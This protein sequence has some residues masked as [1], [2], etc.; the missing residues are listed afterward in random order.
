MYGHSLEGQSCALRAPTAADAAAASAVLTQLATLPFSSRHFGLGQSQ[1][2]RWLSSA[3]EDPDQFVWLLECAGEAIGTVTLGEIDWASA[4]A[5]LEPL[6]GLCDERRTGV[7]SEAVGLVCAYAFSELNLHKVLAR[8]PEEDTA[9]GHAVDAI[10]FQTVGELADDYFRDGR[11][12]SVR[13][14]ALRR[15]STGQRQ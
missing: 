12:R 3:G 6:I 5:S 10:G 4:R 7:I 13:L 11:W 8:V 15:P 2:Q 1:A 9:F 14:V